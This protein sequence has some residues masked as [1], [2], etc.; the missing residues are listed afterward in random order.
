MDSGVT[1]HTPH[2]YH[3]T[4]HSILRVIP[5]SHTLRLLSPSHLTFVSCCPL[6]WLSSDD[7]TYQH[8]ENCPTA[9]PLPA[10]IPCGSAQ[11]RRRSD[12]A[13]LCGLYGGVGFPNLD[14]LILGVNAD[15]R[16]KTLYSTPSI[17]LKVLPS[18]RTTHTA[19]LNSHSVLS[20][21]LHIT[22]HCQLL[23]H[24]VLR[25]DVGDCVGDRRSTTSH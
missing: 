21:H 17:Y 2:H 9:P 3:H 15:G 7:F 11:W 19:Q 20:A 6:L 5:S 1:Q 12:D 13:L 10:L 22:G 24:I 25:L 8:A 4:H 18:Q 16:V 14:K 23:I